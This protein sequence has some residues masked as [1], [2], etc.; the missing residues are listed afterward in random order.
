MKA[1]LAVVAVLVLLVAGY[2]WWALRSAEQAAVSPIK[3][4]ATEPDYDAVLAVANDV[5]QHAVK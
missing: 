1:V 5:A 2:F 4:I 3:E